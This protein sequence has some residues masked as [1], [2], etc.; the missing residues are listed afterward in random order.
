MRSIMQV[1][2]HYLYNYEEYNVSAHLKCKVW[3]IHLILTKKIFI[4]QLGDTFETARR[5][6]IWLNIVVGFVA[7]VINCT[8]NLIVRSAEANVSL[9][10]HDVGISSMQ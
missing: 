10:N 3:K 7:L 4:K 8:G 1:F 5:Q 2:H 6:Q 9:K